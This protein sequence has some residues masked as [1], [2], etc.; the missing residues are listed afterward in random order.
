MRG[1]QY[2]LMCLNLFFFYKFSLSFWKNFSIEKSA[3][4]SL[5]YEYLPVITFV[6][7]LDQL[8]RGLELPR[9]PGMPSWPPPLKGR[10]D[11]GP[12][13]GCRL[14][15]VI[16]A[17]GAVEHEASGADLLVLLIIVVVSV[18]LHPEFTSAAAILIA[19]VLATIS[20][21]LEDRPQGLVL[22]RAIMYWHY[23]LGSKGT[24][25]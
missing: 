20:Q 23:W 9:P 6:E 18:R 16:T 8:W 11:L 1:I 24:F 4:E 3:E 19:V 22:C 14:V 12:D 17:S 25:T 2:D 21:Q 7:C 10:H 13:R 5:T 15:L